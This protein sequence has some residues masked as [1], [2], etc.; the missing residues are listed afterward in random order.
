MK[1]TNGQVHSA[2]QAINSIGENERA[3]PP[4]VRFKLSKMYEILTP[5]FMP[6]EAQ[7]MALIQTYGAKKVHPQTGQEMWALGPE[8]AN[9][10]KY[11]EEWKA[12]SE[13]DAG[14]VNIKP[15]TL[16]MFGT[17]TR[18]IQLQEIIWL[19]PLLIHTE[20]EA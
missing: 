12:V 6:I 1:L 20:E 10:P 11:L 15:V 2:V 7:R 14:E 3:I 16:H 8:D 4:M 13:T 19:G 17:D 9:F 5:L 18:G